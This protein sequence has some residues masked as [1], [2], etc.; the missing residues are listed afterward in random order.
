METTASYGVP[1]DYNTGLRS[2][3]RNTTSKRYPLLSESNLNATGLE[4]LPEDLLEEGNMIEVHQGVVLAGHVSEGGTVFAA[5]HVTTA[6]TLPGLELLVHPIGLRSL[7]GNGVE[8]V[9]D[10]CN[11]L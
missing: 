2:V 6:E 7:E 8:D 10:L 3:Q 1:N 4:P 9:Q 11:N 5:F